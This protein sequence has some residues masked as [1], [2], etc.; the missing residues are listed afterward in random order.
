[1]TATP[2]PTLVL[3]CRRPLPGI[4]KQRIAA[5]TNPD[6]ALAL[7]EHLLATAL[8]D[9]GAWRGPTVIAPANPA[10]ADW[11][12]QQA[13]PG[14]QVLPQSDGNLGDRLTAMDLALRAQGHEQLLF[15]GSDAP[16]LDFA[17]FARARHALEAA[18]IVLGPAEDGGVTLMGGRV[19]WPTLTDLPWS[20]T[21]LGAALDRRCRARGLRVQRLE[22]RYDCDTIDV[23]PRLARELAGDPRAARQALRDWLLGTG[24]P[25]IAAT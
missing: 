18:D 22:L 3:F 21:E 13:P 5:A 23:L 25:A 14:A 20:S 9:V 11:M 8:E 19:P 6:L 16:L 15:I 1:M 12:R 4:G 10:D 2:L 17:Y 24:L 7:S